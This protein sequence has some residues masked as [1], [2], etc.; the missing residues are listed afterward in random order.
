MILEEKSHQIGN[1]L[2]HFIKFGVFFILFLPMVMNSGFFFPFV[3]PKN[4]L[5][6]ISVEIIFASYLLLLYF[7]PE[8]R[9]KLNNLIWAVLAFFGL[10]FIST[11]S[12][13]GVYLSFWGN[14][15][16]MGGLFHHLHLLAYFLVLISVIKR[17]DDWDQFFSFSIFVSTLMSFLAYAQWLELPF[18]LPSSGGARLTGM[19]GNATYLAAY[20]IFNVFFVLY[21]LMKPEKFKIKLFLY[22]FLVF[23]LFLILIGVLARIY[24]FSD[25]GS[26]NFLKASIIKDSL[27]YPWFLYLFLAFQILIFLTWY[28]RFKKYAI[29]CLLWVIFIFQAWVILNTQTRGAVLGL[30]AGFAVFLIILFFSCSN[31]KR[32][33]FYL[34]TSGLILFFQL[35]AF[36]WGRSIADFLKESELK[37][38][39]DLGIVLARVSGSISL[40]GFYLSLLGISIVCIYFFREKRKKII[41]TFF[42]FT[43]LLLPI[44]GIFS[45]SIFSKTDNHVF[46]RFLNFSNI[47]DKT[48]QSRLLTWEASWKGL[49]ESPK[50]F[51]I[52][53]GLENYYYI[54][55]KYF[56]V[57][58]YK[59][60]GSQI[61]FDRPHNI[62]FDVASTAGVLGLC[63][64]LVILGLAIFSLIKNYKL[65]KSVRRTWLFVCLLFAYLIQNFFVFDTLNTEILF[66][67]VLAMVCFE[68][69]LYITRKDDKQNSITKI[70]SYIYPVISVIIVVAG[71]IVNINIAKAN[72][73]LVEA[74]HPIK[75]SKHCS[76]KI[77]CFRIAIDKSIVGR[78]EARQQLGSYVL[79][80]LG[81]N[82]ILES[83][84]SDAVNFTANELRKSV[85]EEPLNVRHYLFLAGF[86][87]STA[88]FNRQNP[89][90][91]LGLLEKAKVLSPTR[92]HI[93][94]EMGKAYYLLGDFDN[95]INS[96]K[97]AIELAPNV[98]DA[99][100]NLLRSYIIFGQSD[101]FEEYFEKMKQEF[102]WEPKAEEYAIMAS[103]FQISKN[104][105]KM[106]ELQLQAVKLE[107]SFENYKN[108]VV[109]YA[110]AQKSDK[111]EDVISEIKKISSA[112]ALELEKILQEL[113]NLK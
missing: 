112:A 47:K 11:F 10:I 33:I 87:N 98:I 17:K 107:P 50:T 29:S 94:Y 18:L 75:I 51:L 79:S 77:D 64:Y 78:F 21:F 16:R 106:I 91:T 14:Y 83:K 67:L 55:N 88:N 68:K 110:L 31:K 8:Y 4:I 3:V 63:C 62:I 95:S 61:W 73:L 90:K 36:G 57:E 86:Y 76:E 19:V 20:L 9:P 71:L 108:L 101:L 104:Y 82:R 25:W 37:F 84:K 1:F 93:Y 43:L 85:E 15:E 58:I 48:T 40:V 103:L 60:A 111:A 92:P 89:A 70:F 102:N 72:I 69:N 65:N 53:Y 49:T 99:H 113:N 42:V 23:D 45:R 80:S 52:G 54:F 105:D 22:S 7:K 27:Y 39:S 109:F 34:S 56:P 12:G 59:N 6:R 44:F 5:F 66:F 100:L 38:F 28:F 30:L 74:I 97:E 32:K 24:R 2:T 96:F 26:F 35:L 46:G 41:V 13:I 81:S